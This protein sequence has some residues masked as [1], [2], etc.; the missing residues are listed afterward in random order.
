MKLIS[1]VNGSRYKTIDA[2]FMDYYKWEFL[3]DKYRIIAD[4]EDWAEL[5][6]DYTSAEDTRVLYGDVNGHSCLDN[7]ADFTYNDIERLLKN[8]EIILYTNE[9]KDFHILVQSD[10]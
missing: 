10:Y 8:G 6:V 5:E 9:Y 3:A 2:F 1:S 4:N 7:F